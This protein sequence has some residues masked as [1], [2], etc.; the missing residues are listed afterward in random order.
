MPRIVGKPSD[1]VKLAH[2]SFRRDEEIYFCPFCYEVRGKTDKDGKFYYN[3]KKKVG[4][5]FK[6]GSIVVG[7][8]YH[9]LESSIKS[10]LEKEREQ[11]EATMYLSQRYDISKIPKLQENQKLCD[12]FI[13][14]GFAEF[15]IEKYDIRAFT[16]SYAG[17]LFPNK[18]FEA[19][20]DVFQVRIVEGSDKLRYSSPTGSVKPLFNL[21]RLDR[22]T[23][24]TLVLCEGIISSL[25]FEMLKDKS[26]L[27]L[28]S[29]GKALTKFQLDQ[30]KE[31]EI[32]EVCLCYDGGEY[33]SFLQA[34]KDLK[35]V[36][37]ECSW[38]VLPVG[39]DPN[40]VDT[41]ILK[42]AFDNRVKANEAFISNL[43]IKTRSLKKDLEKWGVLEKLINSR[44]SIIKK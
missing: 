7:S 16:D 10:F 4:Q 35:R 32:Q 6:C 3:N 21:W 24:K 36:G 38:I 5:C 14:R 11:S 17:V 33:Q 44:R 15:I 1:L 20:T 26:I 18:R 2:S 12:Y 42:D 22:R 9:D 30:I 13:D 37:T 19:F 41:G 23:H 39:K 8:E 34:T 25:S 29:Y 31:K 43:M 28:A 40:D 27:N